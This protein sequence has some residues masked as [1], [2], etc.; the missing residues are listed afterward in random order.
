MPPNM[1][2]M[3]WNTPSTTPNPAMPV[4]PTPKEYSNVSPADINRVTKKT[5]TNDSFL[6]NKITKSIVSKCPLNVIKVIVFVVYVRM[7]ICRTVPRR[8]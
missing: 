3:S 7:Y 8:S 5:L 6:S 2:P 4:I 1:T